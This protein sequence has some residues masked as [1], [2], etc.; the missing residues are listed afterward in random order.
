M[1][2]K[3]KKKTGK[4]EINTVKLHLWKWSQQVRVQ[5]FSWTYVI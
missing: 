4:I 1:T 2:K 5:F 3:E